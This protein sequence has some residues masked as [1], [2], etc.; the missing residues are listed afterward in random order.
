[1]SSF[2]NVSFSRQDEL[3]EVS[4]GLLITAYAV[5]VGYEKIGNYLF[6]KSEEVDHLLPSGLRWQGSTKIYLK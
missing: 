2:A 4:T 5:N 6:Q 3:S 1:M